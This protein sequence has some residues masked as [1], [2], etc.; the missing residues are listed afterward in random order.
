MVKRQLSIFLIFILVFVLS[1]CTL[2]QNFVLTEKMIDQNVLKHD[3][4]V[5]KMR[6]NL[7][8]TQI[9]I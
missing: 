8:N 9:L 1:G 7:L 2:K 6:S 4:R 5:T 3:Y